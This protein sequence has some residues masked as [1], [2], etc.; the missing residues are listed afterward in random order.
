MN[1]AYGWADGDDGAALRLGT[2]IMLIPARFD[3]DV[4]VQVPRRALLGLDGG[5][6]VAA[7]TLL[8]PSVLPYAQLGSI[9][10]ATGF[11]VT[12]GYL[13]QSIAS[14]ST[15][16]RLVLRDDGW[17]ATLAYQHAHGTRVSHYFVTGVFGRPFAHRCADAIYDCSALKRPWSSHGR[18]DDRGGGE[19]SA[20]PPLS[21]FATDASACTIPCCSRMYMPSRC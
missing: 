19:P 5:V 1:V 9:H 16:T 18:D 7:T 12:G 2:A 13:H 3:P 21:S 11:Y 20:A 8:G 6:G 15:A 4:Y 17:L 14:D 10:D